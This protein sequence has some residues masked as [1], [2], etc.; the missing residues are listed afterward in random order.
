MDQHGHGQDCCGATY[1]LDG[2]HGSVSA[3]LEHTRRFLRGCTPHLDPRTAQ[4]LQLMVAELVT[5]AV[6]HAPGPLTL[7]LSC[8]GH[9]KVTVTDTSTAAPAPRQPALE[10]GGGFGWHLIATLAD[11]VKVHLAP[12]H[13]KTISAVITR[14]RAAE[15][16]RAVA[17]W[18]G[19]ARKEC[20]GRHP[21]GY[22]AAPEVHNAA[23]TNA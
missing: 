4:D 8:E 22:R 19:V 16:T 7:T 21:V 1:Q 12:P 2:A 6:R 17:R 10:G 18:G 11:Q 3:A 23:C 5:N 15:D 20:S 14:N 13:G 9:F